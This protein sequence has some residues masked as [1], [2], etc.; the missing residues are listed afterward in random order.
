M[1][2]A[3][4]ATQLAW[5]TAKI[6]CLGE[7][8]EAVDY[9][10]VLKANN[11]ADTYYSN[12]GDGAFEKTANGMAGAKGAVPYT[13]A[14]VY[15]DLPSSYAYVMYNDDTDTGKTSEAHAH[16]KGVVFFDN[17]QGFW[18]IHSLPRYP[19]NTGAGYN[20][21][22]DDTYG[23]TF[24]CITF[25]FSELETIAQ[26]LITAHPLIYDHGMSGDLKLKAPNFFDFIED[27]VKPSKDQSKVSMKSVGGAS[28]T[29][30]AKSADCD[31]ELY[32]DVIGPGLKTD[33]LVESW[34][35]G[36]I[37]NKI[38]SSCT[39]DGYAYN[40][41]DVSIVTQA[42]GASWKE[43]QDHSKWAISGNATSQIR[44]NN[45]LKV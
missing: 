3:L 23:Q 29:H 18:L 38:I 7:K 17:T 20:N 13:L 36:A 12:A 26:Q 45:F 11:G 43:T 6:S 40:T 8:G 21:L 27:K 1:K 24:L 16:A 19:A 15:D 30:F 31:C 22:P 10:H 39:F 5:A 42:D 28:F 37:S 41:E 32:A 4:L 14:Q 34:M 2:S 33:L 44:R 35:N 9:F 25:P